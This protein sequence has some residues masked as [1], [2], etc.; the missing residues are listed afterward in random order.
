MTRITLDMLL[1]AYA[2]GIFPMSESRHD[3]HI[4]WFD[5][6]K[7]G[8]LPME[9]FHVPRRLTRTIR[10][11]PYQVRTD[12]AFQAVVEGCA[13]PRPGRWTTWI[14]DSIIQMFTGLYSIGHAHSI[15]C[16]EGDEL[17]GGLYGVSLGAAF[18][19]ESMFSLHR[20]ASKIAL[21]YLVARL[22]AA[23]F[24]LLDTQFVTSH[25][26]KFGAA[27]ISRAEY[28]ERLKGAVAKEAAFH[29]LPATASPDEILMLARTTESD[30]EA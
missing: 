11:A 4:S 12:T 24:T 3:P 21:V 26:Q 20:D 2:Q 8:V 5:P 7:R 19:G 14:N 15:E 25:L 30:G 17:V 13:S 1:R 22:R 27:E 29:R 16:W 9:K 28:L 18:F 23:G 10:D 6:H